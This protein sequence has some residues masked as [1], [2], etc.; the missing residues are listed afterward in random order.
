MRCKIDDCDTNQLDG[1]PFCCKKHWAKIPKVIK[2]E[3]NKLYTIG[4]GS[5]TVINLERMSIKA[6]FAIK[7]PSKWEERSAFYFKKHK[8]KLKKEKILIVT[9]ARKK[10]DEVKLWRKF[11]NQARSLDIYP[12]VEVVEDFEDAVPHKIAVVLGVSGF[13]KMLPKYKVKNGIVHMGNQVITAEDYV[14][15]M[16]KG[17]PVKGTYMGNTYIISC[18]PHPS[19]YDD[20]GEEEIEEIKRCLTWAK[21]L[22][23]QREKA[24]I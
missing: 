21:S 3:L 8:Q 18:E 9:G 7:V 4:N 13:K 19:E 6:N 17:R 1:Q 10:H 16:W 15:S 14:D 23:T 12:Q 2:A 11:F 22:Y 20:F 24:G 5:I